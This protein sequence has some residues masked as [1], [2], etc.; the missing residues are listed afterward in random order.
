MK[1]FF[2]ILLLLFFVSCSQYESVQ[3]NRGPTSTLESSNSA[4]FEAL[5]KNSRYH[6]PTTLPATVKNMK[7]H[8]GGESGFFKKIEIVENALPGTDLELAFFIYED[9][10]SSSYLT[11]KLIEASQRGVKVYLLIDYFMSIKT[12]NLFSFI[13]SHPNI[14]VKRFRPASEEFVTFLEEDLGLIDSK[15]FLHGI[16]L[17]DPAMLTK[18]L[19]SSPKM[20]GLI[21]AIKTHKDNPEGLSLQDAIAA[22]P[23]L[24]QRILTGGIFVSGYSSYRKMSEFLG[25]YLRRIHHKTISATTDKGL[26]FIIGGRNVSDEYHIGLEELNEDDNG[27]L[28]GRAYPFIDSEVSGLI[29]SLDANKNFRDSFERLWNGDAGLY[30]AAEKLSLDSKVYLEQ[31]RMMLEKS[32]VFESKLETLQKRIPGGTI[33]DVTNKSFNV[34][35][36]ENLYQNDKEKKEILTSWKEH[37]E[38]MKPEDGKIEIISAYLYLYPKMLE[39]LVTANDNG[40]EIELYTNSIVTTDLNM[41]NLG[42]YME[43]DKWLKQLNGPGKVTFYELA[44]HKGQGSLHAKIMKTGNVISIGSANMDPRSYLGDTNNM[45]FVDYSS[46]PELGE[47]IFSAYRSNKS[48]PWKV[49]SLGAAKAILKEAKKDPGTNNIIKA[50]SVDFIQDQI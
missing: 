46:N 30:R 13:N 22:N 2:K 48:I 1:Y 35:Y 7:V 12:K 6:V 4:F 17:Q 21:T 44:L 45:L 14:E 33:E 27:L 9:D 38:T 8:T 16:A 5:N 34:K 26:E 11:K 25:D 32:K 50:L 47:R 29:S 42:A 23:M 3:V 19:V 49:L 39:A 41:V 20:R 15:S 18:G 31:E 28:A 37:I 24:V 40:V 43:M 10:Y 36:T